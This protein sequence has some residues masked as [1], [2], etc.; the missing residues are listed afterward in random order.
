[1]Q[2]YGW[3]NALHGDDLHHTIEKWKRSVLLPKPFSCEH[4]LRRYDGSYRSFTVNVT[5]IINEDQSIHEWIAVHTD[6]TE[7]KQADAETRQALAELNDLKAAIDQ[8]AIVAITDPRGK[9]TY[10]NEKF[11]AISQ[12]SRE[13]L[14]GQD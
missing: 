9:I 4:R 8:H 3:A 14:L 6:V 10:V 11:C 1:Y 7:R 2:G 13:E 5:P 12:Y